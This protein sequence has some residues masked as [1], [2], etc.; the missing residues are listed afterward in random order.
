MNVQDDVFLGGGGG[1]SAF[2]LFKT[3]DGDP[4]RQLGVGPMG[5]IAFLDIVPLTLQA[6]NIAAAAAPSSGVAMT[7][8]AGT[9]VTQGIAPDGSG[10]S[11]YQFD[12]PRAVSL[13]SGGDA[14]AVNFLV[15]GFD[16]YGEPMSEL[17][18]GPNGDTVDGAKAFFSVVS[19]VPDD[20]SV[21]TVS[22]GSS[23]IFGLPYAISDA[24][25]IVSAKWNETLAQ[26]AGTFVAA[27]ATAATT[28]TGDVRGTFKP[29]ANASN[30]T[31]RLVIGMALTGAQCGVNSSRAAV[32][33]VP[34]A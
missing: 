29:S 16:F 13:T 17:I 31:R 23:D 8:A 20:T 12:V 26:D 10:R 4:T 28:T 2:S 7:L 18:G 24:G 30:G 22:V 34:Q 32:V 9:G 27:D 19:V 6:D 25:Y 21:Q 14:S 1:P 33:G 3:A 5:R 11:V 15:S